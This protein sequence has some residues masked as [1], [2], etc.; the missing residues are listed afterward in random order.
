M[1]SMMQGESM[2]GKLLQL[3]YIILVYLLFSAT[4]AGCGGNAFEGV[5]DDD[6]FEA[7]L[8]AARMNID[9]GQYQEAIHIL[10]NLKEEQPHNS[11]V[12]KYLGSA[13][14]GLAGLDTF[15]LLEVIDE[16]DESNNSGGIDM[17][18]LV[19]GDSQGLLTAEQITDKLD[20]LTEAID[21]LGTIQDPTEDQVVQLGL[22]SVFR[23][24]LTLA[25]VICS[26]TG[27]TSLIVTEEG[28]GLEYDTTPEFEDGD[29]SPEQCEN[30]TNDLQ[31]IDEAISAMTGIY[32]YD[33]DLYEDFIEF[34]TDFDQNSDDDISVQ[35][36]ENYIDSLLG[37]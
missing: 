34:K 25:E 24:G 13:Y 26:D 19:L 20:N 31:T 10:G 16:L 17:V 21:Q 32:S 35:E 29:V 2:M 14:A 11:D 22:L 7:K 5:S 3:R 9:D 23:I 30:L 28:V 4:F 33:N 18:G 36:L 15:N 1:Q 6:S 37:A 8:E 12:A 27:N